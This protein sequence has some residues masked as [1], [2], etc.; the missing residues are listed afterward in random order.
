MSLINLRNLTVSY[1]GYLAVHQVSGAFEAGSLTA[2]VGPNGAGKSS[3]LGAIAG[4]LVPAEG[5]VALASGLRQRMA[6][7]PQQTLVD[8]SVPLEVADLV[9]LGTWAKTGSTRA[10]TSALQSR[11]DAA[12]DAVGLAGLQR[13]LIVELSAGQL[14]RALFARVL[15]QDAQVILL[16]EP[17]N[18]IDARTTADLLALVARWHAQA[19]TVIAVLHDLDQVRANF[20]RTLLLARR[21]IAWGPTAEVL[22]A[23]HLLKARRMAEC[24]GADA[25]LRKEAA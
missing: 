17:F 21:C 8:R 9:A 24:W 19:R 20:S 1:R 11:V 14:Q 10:V 16:D 4:Q 13:R 2:I 15:V 3:L 22:D 12:L 6:W 23:E 7:L 25:P 5:E 18:A